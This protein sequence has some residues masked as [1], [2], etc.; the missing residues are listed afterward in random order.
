MY[1]HEYACMIIYIQYIFVP[2]S[3]DDMCANTYAYTDLD[4]YRTYS[5]YVLFLLCLSAVM[6]WN[7]VQDR[8]QS[9]KQLCPDDT[10]SNSQF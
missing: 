5:Q 4:T 10:L 9:L 6:W 8:S 1:I 7:K 3:I 2:T